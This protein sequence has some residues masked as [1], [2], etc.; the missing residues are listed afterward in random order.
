MFVVSSV[1]K[2]LW[3]SLPAITNTLQH[4]VTAII[5]GVHFLEVPTYMYTLED[6]NNAVE[7]QNLFI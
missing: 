3:L 1:P 2:Q 5:I 6:Q 7:D 4:A